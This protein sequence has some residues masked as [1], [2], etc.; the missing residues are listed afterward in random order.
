MYPQLTLPLTILFAA[1]AAWLV[2]LLVRRP[3]LRRLALRQV[4]RR[5][6]E[7]VLVIL[8]SMLGTALIVASLAVGDSL[9]R[10]VRQSAYDVLGPVDE[11]VRSPSVSVGDEVA[12]RLDKLRTDPD[13][14]GVLTVRGD[15]AAAVLDQGGRRLAEPRA[16]AWEVDFAAAAEFGAPH[17]SG[18]SVADPGPGRV[19]VNE[20]L[21]GSLGAGVGDRVTFF[22]YGQPLSA[23]VAAVVP[24]EG[25]GGVGLGSAVNHGA[26]FSPGTLTAVADT[27]GQQVTT[28]TFVSNRG[29]V[30][31]GADLTDTV[32]GRIRSLLG[33]AAASGADVQSPKRE[34]LDAA[35]E[36]SDAL[37]SMFVFI[38]SFSIIAGVMLIVNIFVMLAEERKGQVGVLRAIGMRRRRVSAELSIEGAIYTVVAVLL[39]GVVGLAIGR[40]V[41][42]IALN[43][44]NGFNDRANQLSIVFAVTP[45]SIINGMTG[46]FLIALAAVALTSVRISRINIIAAIRDLEPSPKRRTRNRLTIASAVATALLAAASVPAVAAE[47]G[48]AAYLLPGLTVVASIP[49]LR[50]FLPP[51]PVYA[52][53]GIALLGWGLVAHLV[54]PGV[55]D[56]ASTATYVVM[57]CMLT[58]GS[59][60]LVSQY[61]AVLL[62]PLRRLMRRPSDTALAT[63]LA[64]AYPMAKRFRTGATLSMYCIVVFVIVLLTQISRIVDAGVDDAVNNASAGWTLRADYNPTARWPGAEREVSG[65]PFAGKVVETAQLVTAPAQGDDPK[66]RMDDVPVMAVG[67]PDRV[68]AAPPALDDRLDTLPDDASAWALV[69]RDPSYLLIDVLYGA[70]GGPQGEPLRAGSKVTLTDNGTGRRVTRTVAGVITDG[71]AYYGIGGG[72]FRYPVVMS[73]SAIRAQFGSQARPSSLLIRLNAGTDPAEVASQM[74]GQFLNRGLVAT[75]IAQAVRDS[76]TGNRQFFT[77]MRGY[78]ALGLFV[79]VA[80]LGVVMVKSVRERRRTIAVLRALGFQARTVR[81][82]VMGESTFVAVEGVSIG[83]VLGVLTTWLLYQNSPAFGTLTVEFPIAWTEIGLT[84]GATL[85]ASLLATVGPARRAARIKPAIALRIAD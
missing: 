72:E 19:V 33:P 25:L 38:A 7:L 84:V 39:G 13:V 15:P 1:V 41:L 20:H 46:G 21:A 52:A 54:R 3:V 71:Q 53:V 80:G 58:F 12:R 62:Y 37:G 36:L 18:L 43:L 75:D 76:Y 70:T 4:V 69:I 61:Q 63:R 77:L 40:V 14:D 42:V 59:V 81:R 17:P 8:G 16:I 26:Y 6:A 82:A 32:S 27:A 79:G 67:V 5:P 45:A 74:Q 65:G 10:S 29:G 55:F 57:G 22:V 49:L 44:V 50:R 48:A 73:R 64:I 66:G 30:E 11:L 2:F 31:D 60:L 24:A 68:A 83:T 85:V 23:T 51:R 34:V 56:D 9:D 28:T 47:A 78:L 35:E